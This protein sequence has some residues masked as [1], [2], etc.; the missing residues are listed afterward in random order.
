[1]TTSENHPYT[2]VVGF[3][4]TDQADIALH[5]AVLLAERAG[6]ADIH[7]LAVLQKRR[8]VDYKSAEQGRKIIE[9]A[10]DARVGTRGHA[11]VRFFLHTRF[12]RPEK[13]L[14][15]L[16]AEARADVIVVG[17]H[18][19]TGVE[20][21]VLGSVAEKVVRFAGCAV[22]VARSVDHDA[23]DAHEL[24]PEPPCPACVSTRTESG[25][26]RWWCDVH[27]A[28]HTEPHLYDDARTR[29][30]PGPAGFGS[31]NPY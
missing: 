18:G 17:T 6:A 31:F 26:Q 3:D 8:G 7:V 4:L 27:S 24:G 9:A 22:L 1:M 19:R 13:E 16:A 14:V 23:V 20:R 15:N 11:G 5:Q 10:V 25:G 2:L 28:P 30:R 21:W 29:T 12:G